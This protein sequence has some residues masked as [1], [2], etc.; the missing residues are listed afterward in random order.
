MKYVL[1]NSVARHAEPAL[2]QLVTPVI[3]FAIGVVA[4]VEIQ[5]GAREAA[6][7]AVAVPAEVEVELHAHAARARRARMKRMESRVPRAAA[8]PYSAHAMASRIVVLPEPF[9]PMMPVSPESNVDAR[10]GVL[11]EVLQPQ[12]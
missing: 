11:P 7:D 2:Q 12:R 9:G 3:E 8:L 5:L 10:V 1:K 4:A 6:H